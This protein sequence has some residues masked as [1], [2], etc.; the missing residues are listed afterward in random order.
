MSE[1]AVKKLLHADVKAW[2]TEVGEGPF[3]AAVLNGGSMLASKLDA[4]EQKTQM[5][6]KIHAAQDMKGARWHRSSTHAAQ[7]A[8]AAHA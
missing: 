3:Q 4:L 2:L 5:L 7:K 8:S 6:E 1:E